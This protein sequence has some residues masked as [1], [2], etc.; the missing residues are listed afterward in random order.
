[1]LP[2]DITA[3]VSVEEG[4]VLGWD[5]Y[6]GAGGAKIGMR[7]FGSSAPIEDL[8]TKFGFTPEKVLAAAK[9][10]IAKSKKTKGQIA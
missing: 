2:P 7:T 6:V 3:R 1:V 4:S 10:Q 5:R 9:E 8:M